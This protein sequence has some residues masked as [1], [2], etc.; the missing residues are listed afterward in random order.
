MYL[1]N[2]KCLAGLRLKLLGQHFIVN[3]ITIIILESV[4]I[5]I[6]VTNGRGC[7]T[8]GCDAPSL[9]AACH[10]SVQHKWRPVRGQGS[11][12]RAE[13]QSG[14]AC[15]LTTGRVTGLPVPEFTTFYVIFYFTHSESLF[16]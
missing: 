4:C 9:R 10:V 16:Y 8:L 7:A 5:T 11:G 15:G 6:G 3:V 13:G 2:I 14:H 1:Q 12:P